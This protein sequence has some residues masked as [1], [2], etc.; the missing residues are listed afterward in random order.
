MSG[1]HSISIE[2]Y[3]LKFGRW[4]IYANYSH[5]ERD[6]CIEA[7]KELDA[8]S[9]AEGVCV[10]RETYSSAKNTSRE[11]VIYHSPTMKSPPPVALVTKG[12]GSKG[13]GSKGRGSKGGGTKGGGTKGGAVQSRAP[14][15]RNSDD[16]EGAW[17]QAENGGKSAAKI[18]EEKHTAFN[19]NIQKL[20]D[21]QEESNL[22]E[23]LP[24]LAMVCVVSL[25]GAS[26]I[27][28]V[29][30]VFLQYLPQ[31]GV[32]LGKSASQIILVL[33]FVIS[34]LALFVPLMRRFVPALKTGSPRLAAMAVAEDLSVAAPAPAR[35]IMAEIDDVQ[36]SVVHYEDDEEESESDSEDGS[37]EGAI[38]AVNAAVAGGSGYQ[39]HRSPAPNRGDDV[40]NSAEDDA[41]NSAGDNVSN[42]AGDDASNSAG[43]NVNNSAKVSTEMLQFIGECLVPLAEAGRPLDAFNRFGLTLYF[44][45]AGEYLASQSRL[46]KQEIEDILCTHMQKLGHTPEMARG[47]CS[48]IDEY[49]V[50][51]KYFQMYEAGRSEMARH[52]SDPGGALGVAGA[53]DVWN[54]PAAAESRNKKEFVAVLFTDIVGSTALTQERGDDAA[55]LV[56]HE[57]NTIVREALA[58]HGGRE[59][60]HT[61][62][63]IMATFPQITNAVDGAVAMQQACQRANAADPT[64]GLGLCIGVNA[65]EPIHE[66]GDVFGTPVQ[67]AARVLSKAEEDEIAVSNL[68]REMCTGKNYDFAKKGDYDLKGFAEPVPIYLVAWQ[69]GIKAPEA[70]SEDEPA[71]AGGVTVS[72]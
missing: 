30:S 6:Q 24:R 50:N 63:G 23:V 33:A 1:N 69:G 60:K 8:S 19:H 62:D 52:A 9:R 12:R 46:S 61:G 71:L 41:S 43:D 16:A 68:V 35:P 25:I 66:N 44:C 18:P 42:S 53:M 59:I 65:G 5:N 70:A 45:G 10:V 26:A 31:L 15:P 47:F 49:L 38:P 20:P 13:R 21:V 54:E 4:E 48:N 37:G 27:S 51:P 34:F 32:E 72:N 39:M 11:A 64:L 14:A 22:A 17:Q 7:A 28:Y 3:I 67:M 58:L 36:E 40:T 57:H 55:Q 29:I 2:I 56:V